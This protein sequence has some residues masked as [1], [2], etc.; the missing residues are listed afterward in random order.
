M[1]AV[2]WICFKEKENNIVISSFSD[3]NFPKKIERA[4]TYGTPFLFK[5]VQIELDPLIDPILDKNIVKKAG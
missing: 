1:Q 4:I 2:K 3:V 5:D